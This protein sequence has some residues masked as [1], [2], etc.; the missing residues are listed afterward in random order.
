METIPQ[1][2]E[3][4]AAWQPDHPFIVFDERTLTYGQAN[5][6]A[7]QLAHALLELGVPAGRPVAVYLPSQP[8]FALAYYG[9]L[10]SG[11]ITAPLNY[12][13]KA[14]E[15]RQMVSYLGASAVITNVAGYATVR[16]VRDQLPDL[17]HVLVLR[18]ERDLPLPEGAVDL[19]RLMA[20]APV[21]N[22]GRLLS[23]DD[24]ATIFHTSGTTGV[25]KGAAQTHLN[26]VLGSRQ[27]TS[28]VG[29]RTAR[30]RLFCAL[31][32]F[33]NFG[34]T[35]V[36]NLIVNTLG[37]I[38]LQER[39]DTEQALQLIVRHGCNRV[40]GTPTMFIYLLQ[41]H[42]PARHGAIRLD[43]CLVAGQRCPV[44]VQTAFEE[45]FSCVL[46]DAYGATETHFSTCTLR[47][48]PRRPGSVG[49]PQAHARI[50]IIDDDK[51]EAP[52]GTVGEIVV[53]AE[54]VCKGYWRNPEKTAES[55]DEDG[56]HSGDLG[57]LDDDDYLYIV[58]RKKDLIITGGANIYPAEVE[59]VLYTHPAV[60]FAAVIGIPDAVKGEIPRAY[61]V[62][63]PGVE[64]AAAEVIAHCREQMAV[65]KCPREV[66]FAQSLPLSPVGK[67]LRRELRE[68]VLREGEPI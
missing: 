58:D 5:C 18:E 55:F 3:S 45:R 9:I 39:W 57:Y 68:Q 47:H 32:L 38:V 65:Y 8:T 52:R 36:M 27:M 13:F 41:G 29:Y 53:G 31:P 64:V 21:T 24:V 15:V 10:K 11:A 56:W 48:G 43:A 16:Q 61:V 35:A 50:K 66:V 6:A 63:K 49:L 40:I 28:M 1:L 60:A 2:L 51:Q 30:E 26:V 62:K 4:A 7:N 12:L 34:S 59:E 44:E 14:Q 37:T 33:N 20:R 42:D 25:P 17:E 46:V 23:F 54:T 19:D 22:P 67:V